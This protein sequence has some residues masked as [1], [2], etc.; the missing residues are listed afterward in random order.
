MTPHYQQYGDRPHQVILDLRNLALQILDLEEAE[1]SDRIN[2]VVERN[3]DRDLEGT[4]EALG[5]SEGEDPQEKAH[6][7]TTKFVI[8]EMTKQGDFIN[9]EGMIYPSRFQRSNLH[10][11]TLKQKRA[12]FD[13]AIYQYYAQENVDIE[14]ESLAEILETEN[15]L[16]IEAAYTWLNKNFNRIQRVVREMSDLQDTRTSELEDE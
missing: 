4:I 6:I 2:K 7:I 16:L 9:I 11:L 8:S 1:A 13:S 12:L 3:L 15:P 14:E 10:M 5:A